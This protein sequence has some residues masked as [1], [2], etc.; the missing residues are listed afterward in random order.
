[1]DPVRNPPAAGRPGPGSLERT[2][3]HGPGTRT[4]C[5][6]PGRTRRRWRRRRRPEWSIPRRAGRR[7]GGNP[8][9]SWDWQGKGST[10]TYSRK[11]GGGA[12]GPKNLADS[13]RSAVVGLAAGQRAVPPALNAVL[14]ALTGCAACRS[15]RWPS[16]WGPASRG[17]RSRSA[18]RLGWRAAAAAAPRT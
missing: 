7:R 15:S 11:G 4:W 1:M 2:A 5:R 16:S 10:N 8:A 6:A 18:R 3:R 14:P 17:W 12:V 9:R 13:V